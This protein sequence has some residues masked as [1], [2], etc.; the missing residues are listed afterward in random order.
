MNRPSTP[1]AATRMLALVK[2]ARDLEVEISRSLD[3]EPIDATL[4]RRAVYAYIREERQAGTPPG[5]IVLMLTQLV[6]KA[7]N[8]SLSERSAILR[9]VILWF[10]EAYFGQLEDAFNG[11]WDDASPMPE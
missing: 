9:R 11:P 2:D 4:L 6:D 7:Q 3:H 8:V 5:R 1:R 10:V